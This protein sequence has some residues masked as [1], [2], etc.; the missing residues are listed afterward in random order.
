MPSTAPAVTPGTRVDISHCEHE[1]VRIPGAIQP[2]GVLLVLSAGDLTVV[3]SSDN[4]RSLLGVAPSELLGRHVTRLAPVVDARELAHGLGQER[5]EE[6]NPFKVT[7]QGGRRLNAMVHRQG[8]RVLVELE[9]EDEAPEFRTS[10]VYNRVRQSLVRLRAAADLSDLCRCAAREVRELTGFD[11]VIVYAFQPDWSGRVVA[12]DCVDGRTRYLDLRFPTSDIPSQARALYAECRLRMIPTSTYV[13]AR[14]LMAQ[15]GD[16]LDLTHASLRSISPVH[17]EYMRNMGVTAS[18]GLSIL[19]GDR[20]WGLITC[21]HESGGRFV[22]YE[23]RVACG[24][25][26]EIISSL[27]AQKEGVAV[28]EGRAAYLARQ[29]RIV[30]LVVQ[31]RD[32]V[33]GLTEHSPSLLDVTDSTGAV[34]LY[35]N[36]FHAIGKTPPR[37]HLAPLVSWIRG[38]GGGTVATDTLPERYAPAHAWKDVGCGLVATPVLFGPRGGSGGVA[39]QDTWLLW[40]RPEV[41]QTVSWGG[42]PRK[43]SDAVDADRL[44]PR[45]SFERW[46][47]EVH[48]KSIPFA[49]HEIAAAESLARELVDVVLEIEA[50]QRVREQSAAAAEEAH[51]RG[52][53]ETATSVLH[54]LGNA[55]TGIGGAVVEA[56]RHA[57][58]AAV[59]DNLARTVQFLKPSTVALDRV[60]GGSRGQS[61]VTLLEAMAGASERGQRGALSAFDRIADYLTHANEILR[62]Q[63]SYATAGSDGARGRVRIDRV[64]ADVRSMALSSVQA[65]GGT[66]TIE[67]AAGPAPT[68]R[69]DRSRLMS[70]LLNLAKN[71]AEA[72]DDLPAGRSPWVTLAY[73]RA[74]DGGLVVTVRDGGGGFDPTTAIRLFDDGFS[75]KD[76]GSGIG[77]GS[78]RRIVESLGG[79]ITVTSDGLGTGA[80]AEI[81]L[82]RGAIVDEKD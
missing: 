55:L 7:V 34:L 17:L 56:R 4:T 71:A 24:L 41:L 6:D 45:K 53:I 65:R 26:G 35:K 76:R 63:R 42:D 23:A 10:H 11:R 5:V 68:V 43:P 69:V 38:E 60:L 25:L 31:D 15:D 59:T 2:H 70:V 79:R 49:P 78:C 81:I 40:F 20:L 19:L 51:Q 1:P 75:T 9:P 64:L 80:R 61:L 28:A 18:L 30:Q 12:E 50:S 14:L 16:P 22:P 52:K 62:I 67:P 32:L 66:L 37:A 21:N 77:L 48:L 74:P 46:R 13:P 57:A 58:D 36:E 54:D 72:L 39:S 27:V 73:A 33:S 3:G 8:E 44:H 47:E 29:A 82:P